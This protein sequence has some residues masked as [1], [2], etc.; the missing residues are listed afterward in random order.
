MRCLLHTTLNSNIESFGSISI[1]VRTVILAL[2]IYR[3]LRVLSS[4]SIECSIRQPIADE[5]K[6]VL[7]CCLLCSV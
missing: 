4:M 7:S 5:R 2:F 1:V 6:H 3:P